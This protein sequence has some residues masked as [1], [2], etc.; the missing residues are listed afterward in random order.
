MYTTLF[1]TNV[2]NGC[3]NANVYLFLDLVANSAYCI[4]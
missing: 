1:I 4:I 2:G 3:A